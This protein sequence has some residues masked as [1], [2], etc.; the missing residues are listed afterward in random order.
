[1]NKKIYIFVVITISLFFIFSIKSYIYHQENK[2]VLAIVGD[3]KVNGETII[4]YLG[5]GGNISIPRII[6]GITITKIGDYAFNDL[7]IEN[8]VIPDTIVEIGNYSFASNQIKNLIIPS[9]VKKIGEGSFMHNDIRT[10]KVNGNTVIGDGCFNDNNL[11]DDNAFFYKVNSDGT[12]DYSEI[13]SYGG[14]NRSSVTI[15]ETKNG[16]KLLTI[17]NKSFFANNIV[18]VSIPKTITK[19]GTAAFKDN[20]LVEVYLS[21]NIKEVAVDAFANNSYLEEIVIDNYA[22]QLLNYP[23]GA[24]KSNL[25]W[26]K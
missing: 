10:I 8:V 15:P 19:I 20:Y 12:I 6:N 18:S 11:D 17:G 23:W 26:L 7:K 21:N 24:D 25:H 2:E 9:S 5:K 22:S 13:I 4:K 14:K 16:K 1:M 3:F